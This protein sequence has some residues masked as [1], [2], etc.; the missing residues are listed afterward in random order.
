MLELLSRV[1][2]MARQAVLPEFDAPDQDSAQADAAN[3]P[4]SYAE[5]IDG[6]Y[7]I[8]SSRRQI[9]TMLQDLHAARRPLGLTGRR[10]T[11]NTDTRLLA[12]DAAQGRVLLRQLSN[13]ASHGQLQLDGHVNITAR[14]DAVPILFTLELLGS[15]V[16]DGI[17]C[18]VA[19]IPDWILFAQM[20]D[21]FRIRLPQSLQ[22]RLVF[23]PAGG[24]PVEARVLDISETGVGIIVPASLTRLMSI[25]QTFPRVTLQYRDGTLSP[26]ALKVR[27]VGSAI[28]GPQRIGAAMEVPTEALRQNLRRL[29]LHYQSL[30]AR[31]E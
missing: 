31:P 11:R 2:E 20:R 22:A 10:L 30:A 24:A 18:Y 16:F 25:N 3:A 23:H 5:F 12:I 21:T 6:P 8:I 17:P 15:A 9:L 13:D 4:A 1:S 7:Q 19:P 29:I 28:G 14:H 27:Y 26:L